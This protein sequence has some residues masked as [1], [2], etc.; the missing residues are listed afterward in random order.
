MTMGISVNVKWKFKVNGKE[1]SSVEE[2]PADVREAYEKARGTSRIASTRFVFN[3]QAY[4]SV[5]VMPDDVRRVYDKVI[6]AAETGKIPAEV[7]SG[8]EIGPTTHVQDAKGAAGSVS[9]PRPIEPESI[10][11]L[12][13]RI[14]IVG[15][16]LLT[17]L[18]GLYF[19]TVR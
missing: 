9:R 4:E 3:G 10:L 2:M 15:L 12:S 8:T 19:V 18:L 14:L 1:Y 13:P 17:L 11:S 16:A 5:E 6:T 7:L